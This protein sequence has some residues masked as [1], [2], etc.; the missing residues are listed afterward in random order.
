MRARHL[1][2]PLPVLSAAAPAAEAARLL[3]SE[4]VDGVLAVDGQGRLLGVVSDT[5]TLAWLLPRYV[6]E[7]QALARV[8]DEQAADLLWRRLQDRTVQDLLA[9]GPQRR[10][11]VEADATLIEVGAVMAQTALPLVAVRDAGRLVGGITSSRLLSRL[12]RRP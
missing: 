6:T 10:C 12:L 2:L 11:E 4:Q 7:D 9:D 1:A 3:A 5:T 8:L